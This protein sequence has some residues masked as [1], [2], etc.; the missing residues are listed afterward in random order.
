MIEKFRLKTPVVEAG[1]ISPVTRLHRK[2]VL[3]PNA[4]SVA[5]ISGWLSAAM[6]CRYEVVRASEGRDTDGYG[7]MID[8]GAGKE[9]AAPGSWVVVE[10]GSMVW[11][12]SE[13][14]FERMYERVDGAS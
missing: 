13:A 11:V 10:D 3:D 8:D 12:Y 1:F 6:V 9:Y 2:G 4:Q 14:E 7:L 5:E